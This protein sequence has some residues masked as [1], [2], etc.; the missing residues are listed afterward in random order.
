MIELLIVKGANPFAENQ[1]NINM[2]HCG[3]HGDRPI[4]LAYFLKLGLNINSAD[5]R[6]STPLHWAIF[7]GA[8]LSI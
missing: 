8:E 7:I 6:Q 5:K 4:S 2:L 3:V 1:I